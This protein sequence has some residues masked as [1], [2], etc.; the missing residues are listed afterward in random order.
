MLMPKSQMTRVKAASF[1]LKPIAT[2]MIRA[3][4]TMFCRICKEG[5]LKK[6]KRSQNPKSNAPTNTPSKIL[7]LLNGYT[8]IRA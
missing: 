7:C 1:V 3:V 5:R 8:D 6:K 4:P 2:K